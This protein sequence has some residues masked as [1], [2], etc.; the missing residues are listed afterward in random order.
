MTLEEKRDKAVEIYRFHGFKVVEWVGAYKVTVE[1]VVSRPYHN[2]ID[3]LESAN[4]EIRD[5]VNR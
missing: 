2:F 1:S 5:A 4:R 3:E